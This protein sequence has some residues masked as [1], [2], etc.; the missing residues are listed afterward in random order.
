MFKMKAMVVA[1]A[2]FTAFSGIANAKTEALTFT[3]NAAVIGNTFSAGTG[4]FLD[5]FTF[6]VPALNTGDVG[7][8]AI[9]GF[10]FSPTIFP[11]VSF[12]SFDLYSGSSKVATGLINSS[13]SFF[14]GVGASGL[15]AGN[16]SLQVAGAVSP[17]GGSYGGSLNMIAT[18][19]P[20]P[21]T[22]AM[23]LAGLGL[24]GFMSRRRI[25]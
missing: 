8:S 7:A 17:F 2:A 23:F 16:Y 21:E 20:E 15:V 14:A 18:P 4:S 10:V 22:Y 13:L 3:N 11:T 1:L 19:V 5:S 9:S 25:K 12:T 24:M 6:T